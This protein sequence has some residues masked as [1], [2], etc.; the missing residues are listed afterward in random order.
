M[1]ANLE[2]LND[3]DDDDFPYKFW[4]LHDYHLYNPPSQFTHL[5]LTAC[6]D[7]FWREL[8]D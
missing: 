2:Q 5:H 4:S 3:D 7:L 6:G 1:Y 8:C